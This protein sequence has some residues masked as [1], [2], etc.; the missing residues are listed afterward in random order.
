[1]AT[2]ALRGAGQDVSRDAPMTSPGPPTRE[3]TASSHAFL[4]GSPKCGTT[5]LAYLLAQHPEVSAAIPKEPNFFS[6]DREYG[7]GAS[8]YAGFFAQKPGAA[9]RLD[10]SVAYSRF[11][12]APRVCER[13]RLSCPN[14]RFIYIARNPYARLESA[15]RHAHD[16]AFR[17]GFDIPFSLADALPLHMPVLLDT[18]YWQRTEIFRDVF[19]PDSI[20]YLTLED[21]EAA[22]TAV[23]DKCASFL[24][25]SANAWVDAPSVTLNAGSAKRC[26]TRLLRMIRRN[27]AA[28]A[29]YQALHPWV[30]ERLEFRLRRS[31]AAL[32]VTWPEELR[33]FVAAFVQDDVRHYL[34]AVG[35][36]ADFWGKD[37]A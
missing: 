32:D 5:S 3:A 1:M 26:D 7:M 23:L 30:Q 33:R 11:G 6:D 20:L 31:Q 18:L 37:F 14:P 34:G 27:H 16:L 24:G 29:V 8:V 4:I 15:F 9:V 13:I 28:W 36:P 21:L 22:H 10:A 19:G 2:D 12:V 17:D 35:K 25:L